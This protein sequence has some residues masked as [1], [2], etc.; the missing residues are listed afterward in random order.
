MI[1]SRTSS[2]IGTIIRLSTSNS[3]YSPGDRSLVGSIYESISTFTKSV[4]SYLQYHWCPMAF[5]V[6]TGCLT[7]SVIYRIR[8]D[9]SASTS[10]VRAGRIVHT[11]STVCASRTYRLMYLFIIIASSA[12]PTTVSTSVRISRAWSWKEINCSIT[13]DAAS[14]KAS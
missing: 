6:N 12:Y 7:S 1:S 5:S 10:S 2:C 4:Y 13:E 14:W 11:V 8:S 3:R 9:G